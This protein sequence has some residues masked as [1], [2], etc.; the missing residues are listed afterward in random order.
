MSAA[1]SPASAPRTPSSARHHQSYDRDR[2][3]TAAAAAAAAPPTTTTTTTSPRRS[4]SQSQTQP[5]PTIATPTT[6]HSR[7]PSGVQPQQQLANVARRDFEQADVA[8][9]PMPIREGSAIP[10]RSDSTRQA[11]SGQPRA[12]HDSQDMSAMVATAAAAAATAVPDLPANGG[13]T[14][15]DATPHTASSG[16]RRRTTIDTT[17]GHWEL[18]KTIGAGSMGKVKLARNKETGEQVRRFITISWLLCV[19]CVLT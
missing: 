13:T 3:Q 4:L 5:Q 1:A 10:T 17:T 9:P 2:Y 7:N 14:K 6:S 15:N 12:R 19:A 8:V 18:G 11:A 16:V